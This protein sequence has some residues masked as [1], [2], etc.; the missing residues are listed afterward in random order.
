MERLAYQKAHFTNFKQEGS[1][2]L[3]SIF[4]QMAASTNL[5]ALRS[6]RCRRPGQ[7]E[8]PQGCLL[9]AQGLPKGH[10]PL[11]EL[12]YAQSC[13]NAW[14]LRVSIHLS[15]YNGKVACL[16]TLVWERGPEWGDSSKPPVDYTLTPRPHLCPLPALLHHQC[17]DHVVTCPSL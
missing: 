10:P 13:Q 1:Y 6:M 4:W 16:S 7:L 11:L 3:S 12:L 5:L 14:A 15:L 9:S 17:R 8:R 2:N